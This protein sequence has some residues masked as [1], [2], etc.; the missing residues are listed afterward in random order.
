MRTQWGVYVVAF[1]LRRWSIRRLKP[2]DLTALASIADGSA[3]STSRSIERLARRHFIV[4]RSGGQFIVTL[5]GRVALM[6]K[7][8][9]RYWPP[10]MAT[11]LF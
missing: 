5:R 1:G 4:R 11:G 2:G 8:R 7:Q 3:R 6:I 9:S 10:S